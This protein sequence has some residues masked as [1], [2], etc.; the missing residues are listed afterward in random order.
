M[1]EVRG[2]KMPLI[3]GHCHVNWMGYT[4][5]DCFDWF[6]S[7]G[8]DKVIVHSWDEILRRHAREYVLPVEDCVYAH[9]MFPNFFI[10][11]A[12]PDPKSP[13]AASQL[14]SLLSGACKGIGELKVRYPLDDPD[15][16]AL[17]TIGNEFGVPFTF[18]ID[19]ILSEGGQWY[20]LDAH[21]LP[22][23]CQQFPKVTFLGHA[24]GFWRHVSGDADV[25]EVIQE[26]GMYPKTVPTP[27]GKLY[28]WFDEFPNLWGDLSAGS[29]L[30]ALTRH[31]DGGKAFLERYQGQLIYASDD[32]NRVLLDHLL[33]L[34]LEQTTYHKLFYQNAAKILRLDESELRADAEKA[35][36]APAWPEV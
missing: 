36:P 35:S 9:R 21:K 30:N 10:P 1:I 5:R 26:H 3:E 13:G 28:D 19:I 27:G 22:A 23:L 17:L 12:A 6:R 31:E 8:V 32:Y 2:E 14:R 11:F 4:I 20:N 16:L 15:T 33:S 25:P 24:P 34:E 7:I 18:H 29:A